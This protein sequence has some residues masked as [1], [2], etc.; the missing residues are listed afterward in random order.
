MGKVLGTI[1]GVFYLSNMP[2]LQQMTL[3]VL[4]EN[5]IS[6]SV[7]PI[8]AFE[9]NLMISEHE[10]KGLKNNEKI[11]NLINLTLK[12]KKLDTVS[13]KQANNQKKVDAYN[14]YNEKLTTLN[15][16]ID[17]LIEDDKGVEGHMFKYA[18]E[19]DLMRA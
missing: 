3:G 14:K 11:T 10:K 17:L 2:T 19:L 8:S 9:N 6:M 1:R 12:L 16:I 18:D 4:T 5:G 7:S 15:A 13:G